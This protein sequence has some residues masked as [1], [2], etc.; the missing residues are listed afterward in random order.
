MPSI[1]AEGMLYELVVSY[2]NNNG[3]PILNSVLS[4]VLL[5]IQALIITGI[6]NE[7]RMTTRHTFLPGLSYLLMTSL[8]PEWSFLSA[9]LMA[10]TFILWAFAK[11]F[12]LYNKP[13][14]N[15]K[16]YNIGL[17]LGLASFIYFPSFLFGVCIII[18]LLVLRP[19]RLNELFLMLLGIT[20][21]FY[22]YAV[23]LFLIDGFT[24]QGLL[25]SLGI[26]PP[27]LN[28]S[29]W[30]VGS[31]VFIIIPFLIGAYYIQTNLRKM[32]IQARKNWS[33]LLLWVLVGLLIGFANGSGLFTNWIVA[34]APF[35]A[36]HACAYYYPPRKWVSS[37]LFFAVVT[38][39]LVQQY[40]TNAWH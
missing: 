37:F 35:A 1:A 6:I 17:L 8:L 20:T 13:S 40:V 11:L 16:I 29:L 14:A 12:Q 38:F 36:F 21:P 4:F 23:Y 28:N 27:Y 15:G 26:T 39:I 2:I 34:V 24:V 18:G 9:P 31:I 7:Y 33:I 22:F 5:Y 3:F 19:F 30:V 25:T 10:T 32:L